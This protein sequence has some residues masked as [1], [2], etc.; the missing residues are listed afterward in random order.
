M[1]FIALLIASLILVSIPIWG[2]SCANMGPNDGLV[3][4][5]SAQANLPYVPVLSSNGMLSAAPGS[6]ATVSPLNE[7]RKSYWN[8]Q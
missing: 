3:P 7:T 4:R 6:G 1:K 5:M 8:A 2:C